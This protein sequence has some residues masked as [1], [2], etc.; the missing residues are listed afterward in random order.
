MLVKFLSGKRRA[1]LFWYVCIIQ[2]VL[3]HNAFEVMGLKSINEEKIIFQ[4]NEKDTS[5]VNERDIIAVLPDPH[6]IQ[7]GEQIRYKFDFAVDVKEL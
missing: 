7:D 6:L 5:F 4:T 2:T 3:F 1:M